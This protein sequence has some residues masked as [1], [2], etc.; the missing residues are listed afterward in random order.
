MLEDRR[1]NRC[2]FFRWGHCGYCCINLTI[3]N[4]SE[5]SWLLILLLCYAFHLNETECD[6]FD[7]V[8]QMQLCNVNLALN[9]IAFIFIWNLNCSSLSIIYLVQIRCEPEKIFYRTFSLYNF[10]LLLSPIE[11]KVHRA[12][13]NLWCSCQKP[14]RPEIIISYNLNRMVMEGF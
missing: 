2:R 9:A 12:K 8:W 10:I 4:I 6:E 13:L 5:E 11:I 14:N 7:V 1:E 3:I